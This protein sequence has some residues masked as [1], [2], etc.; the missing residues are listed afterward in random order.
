MKHF[1]QP[2]YSRKSLASTLAWSGCAVAFAL[3]IG[4]PAFAQA[5]SDATPA[6]S[7]EIESPTAAASVRSPVTVKILVHGA[8]I[9]QPTDGLDHLHI[10]VDHGDVIPVYKMPLTPLTLA[11]G[12]HTLEVDLAGPDHQPL[13]APQTVTFTVKP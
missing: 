5:A 3:A 10:A 13:T 12:Q 11:P 4:V 6:P 2:L 1:P 7:F 8:T 9:G